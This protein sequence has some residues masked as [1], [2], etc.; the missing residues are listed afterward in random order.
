MLI[1]FTSICIFSLIIGNIPNIIKIPK[2]LDFKP[3]NC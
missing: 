3:F 2:I 1:L